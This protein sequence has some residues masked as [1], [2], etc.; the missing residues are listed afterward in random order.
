MMDRAKLIDKI[1]DGD[2]AC[3]R[4]EDDWYL[5]SVLL[6]GFNGYR[7]MTDAELIEVRNNLSI[8]PETGEEVEPSDE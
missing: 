3:N 4:G 2:V 7:S 8:D 1:I 5:R 6:E